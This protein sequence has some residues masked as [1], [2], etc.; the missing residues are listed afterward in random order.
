MGK[1]RVRGVAQ[2][3]EPATR[4][5]RKWLA[6]VQGPSKRHLDLLQKRFDARVPTGKFAAQHIGISG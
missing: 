5:G 3:R 1:H 4:P 6:I 2:K